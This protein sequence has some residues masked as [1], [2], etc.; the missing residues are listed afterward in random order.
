MKCL[1]LINDFGNGNITRQRFLID[2]IKKNNDI[3]VFTGEDKLLFL[4][5]SKKILRI[6]KHYKYSYEMKSILTNIHS[7]FRN[8][9]HIF[10]IIKS[11]APDRIIIDSDYHMLFLK[12]FYRGKIISIN[13]SFDIINSPFT[14]I[15]KKQYYIEYLD[16]LFQHLIPDSVIVPS[17]DHKRPSHRKF[18][19][20]PL[21]SS[22]T[23]SKKS[24]NNILLIEGGSNLKFELSAIN[25]A[26]NSSKLTKNLDVLGYEK[27]VTKQQTINVVTERGSI[28]PYIDNAEVLIIRG[29]LSSISDAISSKLPFIIIPIKNHYEQ[30]QNA[31]QLQD[32]LNVPVFT[33]LEE[34]FKCIASNE[35]KFQMQMDLDS[36]YVSIKNI[37][38]N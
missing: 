12:Y 11:E 1:F 19:F 29:G 6:T 15:K 34:A 8:V 38:L 27:P 13:N 5:E 22:I 37:V 7:Y 9:S 3:I 4:N 16:Y 25:N 28:Q 23:P 18:N 14:S 33:N 36:I 24:S 21:W 35:Y 32:H 17:I 10:S 26:Y 2:N 20:V 30:N 31:K